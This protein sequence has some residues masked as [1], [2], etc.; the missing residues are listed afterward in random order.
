M[1][2]EGV[3]WL[4]SQENR[5]WQGDV[6]T[7]SYALQ[8][9]LSCGIS[10]LDQ[11]V[12]T[13]CE[14]LIRT[15]DPKEGDWNQNDGDT[16]EALRTLSLCG[17]NRQDK[18]IIL[19]IKGLYS[20][21][22]ERQ[23]N[24][25]RLELGWVHPN[26]VSRALVV[27]E[28]NDANSILDSIEPFLNGGITFHVKF[29]SRAVLAYKEAKRTSAS[30]KKA[31]ALLV[32][33]IKN[34][35]SLHGECIGY[36]LQSLV[37]SGHN[38]N[39]GSIKKIVEYLKEIREKDGC[40]GENVVCTSQILIGLSNLGIKYHKPSILRKK[41]VARIAILASLL[42]LAIVIW[43]TDLQP[44]VNTIINIVQLVLG[45]LVIV[46]WLYPKIKIKV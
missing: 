6:R 3:S 34:L 25:L 26:L 32:G 37:A 33:S 1:V 46:E 29:T 9:L 31:E 10:Q 12:Q 44:M 43:L 40:W 15:Q 21:R 11:S 38:I 17:K 5:G 16:A 22:L 41:N 20:L 4:L 19:G 18:A 28:K 35:S 24:P 27:L 23:K 30:L 2:D 42:T 13:G 8:A 7:T 39:D 45:L 14:F 36:L